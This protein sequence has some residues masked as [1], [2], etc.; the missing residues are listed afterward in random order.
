MKKLILAALCLLAVSAQAQVQTLTVNNWNPT[1]DVYFTLRGN[2]SGGGC[3]A[4]HRSSLQVFVPG[5][6][7][8][9]DAGS[10]PGGM[11]CGSCTPTTLAAGDDI[12]VARILDA[13]PLLGCTVTGAGVVGDPCFT[14]TT[15]ITYTIQNS[16]C[17]ACGSVTVVWTS[18]GPGAASLDFY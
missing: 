12:V 5:Q 3:S 6:T 10:V 8:T 18:T 7:A 13:N 16:T 4:S 9:F 17:A 15:S 11:N 14:G 1:C 2:P